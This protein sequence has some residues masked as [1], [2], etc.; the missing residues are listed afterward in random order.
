MTPAALGRLLGGITRIEKLIASATFLIMVVALL[1]DVIGREVFGQG[2]FGSVRVAV[3]ALIVCA[4][5]GFGIAT[6]SGAHL[7]PRFL[8][9]AATGRLE[10]LAVRAGHLASAAILLGLG[11]AAW[12]LVGFSRMIED[13]DVVL[14]VLI[15]PIQC[16]LPFGFALSALR[17]VIFGLYPQLAPTDKGPAE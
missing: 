2:V 7:R 14:D 13:R 16:A 5:A 9:A 17:H 3:Y 10:Q 6:A 8:D 15:W 11:F 1:A 4:M 12:T